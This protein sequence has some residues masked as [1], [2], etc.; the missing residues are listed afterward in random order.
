MSAYIKMKSLQPASLLHAQSHIYIL[1]C[2]HA[3]C[4]I[5]GITVPEPEYKY[6]TRK[7]LICSHE[8][9]PPAL[10]FFGRDV[11]STPVSQEP[12]VFLFLTEC[13]DSS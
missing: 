3:V 7:K 6:C 4:K 5:T 11:G 12:S 8:T 10:S 2:I 1:K 9:L 13:T